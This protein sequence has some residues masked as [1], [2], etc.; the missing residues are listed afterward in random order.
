VAG[1]EHSGAAA[2]LSLL[3]AWE[4]IDWMH[5]PDEGG[6]TSSPATEKRPVWHYSSF[7][8][9]NGLDVTNFSESISGEIFHELFRR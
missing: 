1:E 5:G 9:M 3:K 2:M 4:A 7:E 8:L 6:A